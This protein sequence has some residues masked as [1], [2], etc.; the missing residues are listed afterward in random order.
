MVFPRPY[1]EKIFSE[2]GGGGGW[3]CSQTPLVW[4][5]FGARDVLCVHTP[6][7][8][9]AMLLKGYFILPSVVIFVIK[10]ISGF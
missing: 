3:A 7:K 8:S 6:S 2:G 1:F 9:H 5:A 10:Q 4:S